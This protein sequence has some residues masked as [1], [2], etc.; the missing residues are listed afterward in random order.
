MHCTVKP[1]AVDEIESWRDLYR[2]EMS[3]QIIH[4]SFHRRDGWTREYLLFVGNNAVGYGSI[5]VEGPWKGSPTVFEWYVLPQYRSRIFDLFAALLS[6]SNAVA[7]EIQTNDPLATVMLHAFAQNIKTE[8]LLFHD[9]IT[10]SHSVDGAVIRPINPDDATAISAQ[11]LDCDAKWLLE[12]EGQ[13]AATGGILYHYNRPYGDIYMAVADSFRRR[14]LGA[15]LVQE[16]KRV[17]YEQGSVPA[18]RCNP[19]NVASRKT[20]QKA[21]FVPCGCML[22]GAVVPYAD[23]AAP[24]AEV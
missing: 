13:I 16:L 1:V 17:C 10:T 2:Q 5:V 23:T 21:G 22:H 9:R 24:A 20:L 8:S 12:I 18:A 11:K 7:I 3:C 14:G 19:A 15:Y 4:D 6:A